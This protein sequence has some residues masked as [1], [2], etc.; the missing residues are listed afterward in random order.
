LTAICF[1]FSLFSQNFYWDNPVAITKSEAQFP[2]TINSQN[3]SYVFWQ[4]VDTKQK[5]IYLSCRIYSDFN[6]YEQNEKFAGPF[7]YSGEDAPDIYSTCILSDD[8]LCVA[9]LNGVEGIAVYTSKTN[10]KSWHSAKIKSSGIMIAPRVF[11][12][13]NNTFRMFISVGE[14]NSFSLYES[15]SE[16]GINWSK[17]E[18][19]KPSEKLRN[20][21]IPYLIAMNDSDSVVFQAQYVVPGTNRVSYQLYLTNF[22]LR[23]NQWSEPVLIT[24]RSSLS[25]RDTKEFY[26]YQNQRPFL[27]NHDEK[28]YI[29]WERT[30]KSDS[31][32]WFA[33]LTKK[34]LEPLTSEAVTNEGSANRGR[35]FSYNDKIYITWFDS[36]RGKESVYMA[37]KS[38]SYWNEST[39]AENSNANQFIAPLILNASDD[40]S[41]SQNQK[42]LTYI[43]Q[44]TASKNRNSIAYL[45]PDKTVDL[46]SITP[47]SFKKGKKSSSKSMQVQ[48]ILPKDP[49]NIAGFSYYWGKNQASVPEKQIRNFPKETKLKLEAESGDGEYYLSVIAADYAGNWSKPYT[50]SY[51]LDTTPPESPEAIKLQLDKYGFVSSNTFRVNWEKS[52]SEDASAYVCRLDYA[53]ALPKKLVSSKKRPLKLSVKEVQNTLSELEAA[54]QKQLIKK[55]KLQGLTQLKTLNSPRYINRPNGVYV[56]TVAAIDDVGNLGESKSTL[57]FLNKYQP[58]TVVTTITQQK[59]ELGEVELIIKGSGFTYDGTISSIYIDRDG[60]APYDLEI[61]AEKYKVMNDGLIQK[62]VLSSDL[63]EGTY[64]IGLFHT[65]RGLYFT[66]SILRIEQNGTLKIEGEYRP[67][68]PYKNFN[69]V[70]YKITIYFVLLILIALFVVL[71]FGVV[72]T[73]YTLSVYEGI[74]NNIK[75]KRLINGG[76]LPVNFINKFFNLKPSL[77]KKLIRF[78]FALVIIVVLIVSLSNGM[79]IVKLQEQTLSAGLQNRTEVLLESLCSGVKNFFPSNNLLELSALP[80]QK[81]AMSEVSSITIIGQPQ[82]S[83]SSENLKY[84]WATNDSEIL[85]NIDT[86]SLEYGVSQIS[87]DE[88]LQILSKLKELDSQTS[89]KLKDLS[90]KIEEVSAEAAQLYAQGSDEA[91]AK[92]DYISETVITLRNNLDSTL[93]DISKQASGSYPDFDASNLDYKNTDFIF[94]RP[95]LYRRGVTNN[96]VHALVLIKLSTQTLVDSVQAET[97]RI[98]ITGTLI[99][100]AAIILGIIGASVFASIIVR[101]IRKLESHV[102]MIGHTKNKVHLKGKD[103]VIKSK[104]E[105]GRLGDAINN[106]THQLVTVAEEEALTMDGKAVQNAF[107]P[108]STDD[109]NNKQSTAQYKDEQIECFGYYEGESGVSGDYFDYK[110]LDQDWFV[111]IKCDASGHGI[112]AAII[113]TVVATIFT[114]YFENWNYKKNG[115]NINKVVEQ[116]NDFIEQLGLKGKFATLIICLLNLKTGELYTCNAGDRIIHI[117][118]EKTKKIKTVTLSS[119][120]TAG[121]FSS[122]LL[123]MRGGFVVEKL[124]VNHGDILYL[125]TDGIEEATRRVRTSDFKVIQ[126]ENNGKIDDKKEEFGPDR[127]LEIIESVLNKQEYLLT[128]EQ[129]P[130]AS[131]KLLFDFSKGKATIEETI[132]ALASMEKVFRMYKPD[133]VPQ[134]EYIKVDKKID[135]FLKNYFNLYDFYA[136]S[137]E[138]NATSAGYVDY[139]F[140]QEDEQSDDLT[141]LA[142]KRI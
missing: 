19:F 133:V 6:T 44:Q 61:S 129:N 43:W 124:Q 5:E 23:Q 18:S 21:F 87:Q 114:R 122:D 46:P 56:F 126:E 93:L 136:S 14:E 32:V 108:L 110:R 16:D 120:P 50:I 131:E 64:K 67:Q 4:D 92:A 26:E 141:L 101:P 95:V 107:L 37:E 91:T 49:S 48:V 127:I 39:L 73:K 84:V 3:Y 38:G 118:E 139:N 9:V 140:M 20:P 65:D 71:S 70:K 82:N 88:I 125:Y 97:R 58:S 79:R 123:A 115:F 13:V 76:K 80:Q 33:Q 109:H 72:I 10:G 116:I 142:I 83:A 134:T 60:A 15:Q 132:I 75:I 98:V 52:L 53:G 103:I 100:I 22:D 59:N 29:S 42:I 28:T 121:V 135:E 62:V 57:V 78:T 12:T 34:G 74:N 69:D 41:D 30:L 54:Y 25:L 128:K 55:R 1:S 45:S 47:L 99:A 102:E 63:E 51:T 111:I 113:M 96:Y 112:P 86:Y 17:F 27:Y 11:A 31:T 40:S 7:S 117:Y 66:D 119:A 8:T 137:K 35:I 138:D 89:E 24:D 81:D 90:D 77:R 68:N 106:M 2:V 36:R 105:I 104:D 85:E 130:R 94:Y